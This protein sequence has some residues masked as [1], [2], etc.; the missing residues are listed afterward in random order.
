MLAGGP[1]IAQA[2][3]TYRPARSPPVPGRYGAQIGLII[4]SES[5]HAL[6]NVAAMQYGVQ[7]RSRT[8]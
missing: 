4:F 2:G 5:K 7:A 8:G 1:D 6:G 3:P